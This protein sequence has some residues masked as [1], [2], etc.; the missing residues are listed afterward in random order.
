MNYEIYID[1]KRVYELRKSMIMFEV[2]Q[3]TVLFVRF[4]AV[5]NP[6]FYC[7]NMCRY[8]RHGLNESCL[9][10]SK[11]LLSIFVMLIPF[12]GF[13]RKHTILSNPVARKFILLTIKKHIM[14]N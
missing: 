14:I 8:D 5:F 2:G 4:Y 6:T 9:K 11:I 13:L 7:T 10:P 1:D 12:L 3:V